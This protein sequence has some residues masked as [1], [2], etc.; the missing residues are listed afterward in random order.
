MQPLAMLSMAKLIF[1][2]KCTPCAH[3]RVCEAMRS[4]QEPVASVSHSRYLPQVQLLSTCE[5]S[6]CSH[7]QI[8]TN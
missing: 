2:L 3:G 7:W 6:S 5:K 4:N 1:P 8:Q